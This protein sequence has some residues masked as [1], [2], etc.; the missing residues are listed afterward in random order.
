MMIPDN[1]K[2]RKI[3][4]KTRLRVAHR[5]IL[6]TIPQAMAAAGNSDMTART[7]NSCLT[8]KTCSNKD[9]NGWVIS[10]PRILRF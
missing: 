7:R 9:Q 4:N 6:Y 5:P 3:I 10:G 2:S 1:K 8:S